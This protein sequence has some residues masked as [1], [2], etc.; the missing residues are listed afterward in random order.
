MITLDLTD[1]RWLEFI[2][3]C[4]TATTFHHPSWASLVGRCYGYRVF[5]LAQTDADGQI[6]AGLPV[7]EVHRPLGPRRWVSLP[8]TDQCAPLARSTVD[9]STLVKELDATRR[10]AGVASLEVRSS[11]EGPET[12]AGQVGVTHSLRLESDPDVLPPRFKRSSVRRQIKSAARDGVVVRREESSRALTD[13]F[14]RLHLQTRRRLGV[15]IQ[16][17][18][19]F[20]LLWREVIEPGLGFVLLAYASDVPVAGAVFLAWN[21]T[22]SYK[23]GASDASWWH[24]HP[25]HLLM[26]TAI[27]WGCENGFQTFDFGRSDLA[28]TGLRQFKES[29]GSQETALVYSTLGDRGARPTDSRMHAA[30]G[31]IVRRSP[32]WVCQAMGELLYKYAA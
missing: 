1:P 13:V 32:P 3:K 27:R 31:T 7:V 25:N 21:G 23:Y 29:W 12:R 18:R 8:F 26:W 15:P 2:G 4:P 17:R 24:L 6:N 19:Y 10:E 20:E 11:L 16:P 14:Y 5:G 28:S 9:W 30:V 22:V